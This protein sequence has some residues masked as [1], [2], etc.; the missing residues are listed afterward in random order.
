MF[1]IQMDVEIL[2][3]LAVLQDNIRL[4][5]TIPDCGTVAKTDFG[6][7]AKPDFGTV[8][9]PDCGNVAIPNCGTVAILDYGN[10]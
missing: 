6:T 7:V 3:N 9:I 1:H 2:H 10:T 8:A 4:G 5:E